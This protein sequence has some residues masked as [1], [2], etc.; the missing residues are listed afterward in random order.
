[1]FVR[2]FKRDFLMLAISLF[3]GLLISLIPIILVSSNTSIYYP[4]EIWL[5]SQTLLTMFYPLICTIPFC[6]ELLSE[7]KSGFLKFTLNRVSLNKYLLMRY[8]SSL[9]MVSIVIFITSFI[10]AFISELI[11]VPQH[12]TIYE[13]HIGQ[14]LWG[15]ILIDSPLYYAFFLSLWRIVLA[16]LYFTLAFL[17][18]LFCR[19]SFVALTGPFI[20]SILENYFM[21]IIGCPANSM[22]TSFYIT[23]L[24]PGYTSIH[25]LLVGPIILVVVCVIVFICGIVK[26]R[27]GATRCLGIV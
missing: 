2:I 19:N 1:M 25:N 15:N 17:L 12:Q 7:R 9:L 14:Y 21:S 27:Q 26:T 11:L 22:I 18:S 10:G 20:Y 8:L 16:G 5:Y 24:A 23:R 13:S 4:I 3:I 6:W